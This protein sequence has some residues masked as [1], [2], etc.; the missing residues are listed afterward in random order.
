MPTTEPG[1]RAAGHTS[2]VPVAVRRI[3]DPKKREFGGL[4]DLPEGCG[5]GISAAAL[6]FCAGTA[7]AGSVSRKTWGCDRNGC[8]GL[9]IR[10]HFGGRLRCGCGRLRCGY[11][12]RRGDD[13]GESGKALFAVTLGELVLGQGHEGVHSAVW[14]VGFGW[15]RL[16]RSWGRIE[17]LH[18]GDL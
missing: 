16:G 17:R 4:S 10:S 2:G 1:Q 6:V 11:G 14:G 9:T 18:F 3:F 15:G 12:G 8:G 7:A 13:A 5:G